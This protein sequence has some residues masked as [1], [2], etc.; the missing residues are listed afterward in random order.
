MLSKET[1]EKAHLKI[2]FVKTEIYWGKK[3]KEPN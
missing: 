3:K 2:P 1:P